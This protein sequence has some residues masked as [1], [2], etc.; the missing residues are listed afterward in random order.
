MGWIGRGAGRTTTFLAVVLA[1]VFFRA[2]TLTESLKIEKTM[3]GFNG[4]V[5]QP[6]WLGALRGVGRWLTHHGV[7]AGTLAVYPDKIPLTLTLALL[8]TIAWFLPNTQELIP[9]ARPEPTSTEKQTPQPS[10]LVWSPASR[11]W[12]IAS[13][14]IAAI[15]LIAVRNVSPFIYFNF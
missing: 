7:R 2:D 8:L 15:A 4:I 11:G 12:A 5:L 14:I 1:W 10:R 9:Q 13:G 6:G 3:L